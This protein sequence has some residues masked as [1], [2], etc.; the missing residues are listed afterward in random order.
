MSVLQVTK[1]AYGSEIVE[2]SAV[3]VNVKPEENSYAKGTP[4]ASL[5]MTIDNPGAQGVLVPGKNFYVDF[6]PAEE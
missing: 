3:Y 1:T 5:K 2:L 4:S 6:S